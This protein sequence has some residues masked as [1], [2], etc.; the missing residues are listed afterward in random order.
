MARRLLD[1]QYFRKEDI[2]IIH[3]LVDGER[4]YQIIKNPDFYYYIEPELKSRKKFTEYYKDIKD[5]KRIDCKYKDVYKSIAKQLNYIPQESYFTYEDKVR[6]MGNYNL[7]SADDSIEYRLICDYNNKYKD[8]IDETIPVKYMFFD[9]EVH[10]DFSF[11]YY[12]ELVKIYETINKGKEYKPDLSK[13]YLDPFKYIMEEEDIEKIKVY[14]KDFFELTNKSKFFDLRF[15]IALFNSK[16]RTIDKDRVD[17]FI[18]SNLTESKLNFIYENVGFPSEEKANNRIDAISF[19]DVSKRKLYMYLLNVE[20]DLRKSE[21]IEYIKNEKLVNSDL[22]KFIE[23]F[24]IV[25]FLTNI[26]N[27]HKE[28]CEPLLKE[29]DFLTNI[30]KN[31]KVDNKED[32]EKLDKLIELS[33]TIIPNYEE[34]VKMEIEYKLFDDELEMIKDFFHKIKNDIKPDVIAAHNIKFDILTIRNR[35]TKFEESFDELINQFTDNEDSSLHDLKSTF[36]IDMKTAERKKETTRYFAP[37][38]IILDTLLLYAKTTSGEKNWSLESIAN[39]ELKDSKIKYDFPIFEFYE[40]DVRT[41]IKY[42]AVDTLL[43]MRLEDKIK[44]ITLFQL[45]LSNT[46]TD[47]YNHVYRTSYITNLFKYEMSNRNGTTYVLRNNLS[48][49]KKLDSGESLDDD[50]HHTKKASF[51]GAYNTDLAGKA[52]S[53]GYKDNLFDLDFGAFYPS[54]A[55]TTNLFVDKL[56]FTIEE[57]EIHNDYMFNSKIGFGNKYLGLP[58]ID[59]IIEKL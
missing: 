45:I 37:G 39:E 12:Q 13:I 32:E 54:C 16:A 23:L 44:F 53:Y 8:E 58:D 9:I 36:H 26:D 57:K 55:K 7:Y 49:L 1:C 5:L 29:L 20:N 4:Q 46:K 40:R 50:D 6:L 22:H 3:E 48:R 43:L 34:N 28:Q 14:I 18:K 11:T 27:I 2:A 19:V 38:L 10:S 56:L 47:W 41:F 31:Q 42:S 59:T 24:L 15:Y 33:K 21:D 52:D 25:S 35:L 30:Y 17:N 51:K